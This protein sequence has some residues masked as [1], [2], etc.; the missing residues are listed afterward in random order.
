MTDI[1]TEDMGQH[2]Q[3]SAATH[4]SCITWLP[5]LDAVVGQHWPALP[6]QIHNISLPQTDRY[7]AS[8]IKNSTMK[9]LCSRGVEGV[10][11]VQLEGR[12]C[13]AHPSTKHSLEH[14]PVHTCR[15]RTLVKS[16][17]LKRTLRT[18]SRV[19]QHFEHAVA[20]G[21]CTVQMA[22]CK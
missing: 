17:L 22:Q 21:I 10:Q 19:L 20:S 6:T 16:I 15:Q 9:A 11:I 1:D 7:A 14:C 8:G 2:T 18:A 4:S 3:I 5:E 13:A 12:P